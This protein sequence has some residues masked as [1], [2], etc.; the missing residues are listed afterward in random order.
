M[1]CTKVVN[2]LLLNYIGDDEITLGT[3]EGSVGAISE[4]DVSTSMAGWGEDRQVEA[5]EHRVG[6][7]SQVLLDII[8]LAAG[9][10]IQEFRCFVG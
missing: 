8:F 7:F 1:W 6:V 9:I 10:T 5:A 3:D 4:G 2:S